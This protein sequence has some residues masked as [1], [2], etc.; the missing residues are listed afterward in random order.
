M[1]FSKNKVVNILASIITIVVVGGI[2]WIALWE[3]NILKKES[4]IP[5]EAIKLE[6]EINYI[7]SLNYIGI[8]EKLKSLQLEPYIL[9]IPEIKQEE[10][11]KNNIFE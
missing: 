3:F 7:N 11:G 6:K 1:N 4:L 10:I 8:L 9:E 5:E 2:I